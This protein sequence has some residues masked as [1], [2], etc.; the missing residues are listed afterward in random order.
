MITTL[1]DRT[2]RMAAFECGALEDAEV[3]RLFR[4]LIADG[5]VWTMNA[6]YVRYADTLIRAGQCRRHG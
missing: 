2:L 5:S 3:T 1:K 6:Q 4:E